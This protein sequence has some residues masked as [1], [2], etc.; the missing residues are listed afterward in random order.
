M[1]ERRRARRVSHMPRTAHMVEI[2]GSGYLQSL[3]IKEIG[4]G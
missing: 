1:T 2:A 4:I 3:G